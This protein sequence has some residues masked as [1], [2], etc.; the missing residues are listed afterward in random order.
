MTLHYRL[1][2]DACSAILKSSLSE[3]GWKRYTIKGLRIDICPECT[4][5]HVLINDPK[6]DD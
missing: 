3:Q 2:C 6:E 4:E 5:E 1:E